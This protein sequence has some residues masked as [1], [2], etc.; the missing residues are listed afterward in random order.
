MT[1]ATITLTPMADT[2]KLTV[3]N[4]SPLVD[5][6]EYWSIIGKLQYVCIT[7]LEIAF[8]VNKL[9]QYMNA[10]CDTHWKAVKRV[11]RYLNNTLNHALYFTKG[12]FDLVGYSDADWAS[13]VEDRKINYRLLHLSWF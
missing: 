8:C 3:A 13:I 4:G 5:V 11:L 12:Q 10:L 1:V 7:I 2:P 9:S 6:R